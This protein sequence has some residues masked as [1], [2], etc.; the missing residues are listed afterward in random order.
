MGRGSE[1]QHQVVENLNILTGYGLIVLYPQ[2]LCMFL[3]SVVPRLPLSV[4]NMVLTEYRGVRCTQWTTTLNHQKNRT[5]RASLFSDHIY[6]FIQQKPNAWPT[7]ELRQQFAACNVW[8]LQFSLERV[9]FNLLPQGCMYVPGFN[10]TAVVSI[11]VISMCV[12]SELQL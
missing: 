3:V 9:I 1:R 8:R 11:S 5:S 10:C 6:D 12:Q 7:S 2:G 4:I